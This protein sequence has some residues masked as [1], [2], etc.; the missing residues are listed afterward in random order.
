[1]ANTNPNI[2]IPAGQWVNLYVLSGAIVGS[3]LTVE[4][5]GT[6]DV[7][8]AVQVSQPELDHNSYNVLR[9]T[10]PR[11]TNSVGDS[12]AWAF[13]PNAKGE[14]NVS[15]DAADGF[16]P[17]IATAGSPLSESQQS[18]RLSELEFRQIALACM[19]SINDELRLINARL[20]E[21]LE[22]GIERGDV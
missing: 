14:V 11:L 9:R 22:T 21:A 17:V 16:I 20:E 7:Y 3:Q 19:Q 15:I 4:N 1:M 2:P 8:L 5:T 6:C 13:C 10:D 18:D 12:G